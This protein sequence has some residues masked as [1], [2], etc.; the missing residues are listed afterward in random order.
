MECGRGQGWGR[1]RSTEKQSVC[2]LGRELAWEGHS[3][4]VSA[5]QVEVNVLGGRFVSQV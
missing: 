1:L 5:G 3:H 2:G 4:T